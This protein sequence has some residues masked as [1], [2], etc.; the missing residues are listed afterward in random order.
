[1]SNIFTAQDGRRYFR[2]HFGA[3]REVNTSTDLGVPSVPQVQDTQVRATRSFSGK[4]EGGY[5]NRAP[6]AVD[7]PEYLQKHFPSRRGVDGEPIVHAGS[8]N[9]PLNNLRGWLSDSPYKPTR[10]PEEIVAEQ[11]AVAAAEAAAEE[12]KQ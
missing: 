1:M 5:G 12:E 4:S 10:L 11:I 2:D 6:N 3:Y 7:D 8:D 9:H